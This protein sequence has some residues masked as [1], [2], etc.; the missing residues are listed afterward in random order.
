MASIPDRHDEVHSGEFR[1]SEESQESKCNW[2]NYL[3]SY[4]IIE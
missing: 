3:R 4:K 2:M 1:H